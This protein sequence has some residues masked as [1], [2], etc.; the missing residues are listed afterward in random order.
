MGR[1]IVYYL[2]ASGECPTKIFMESLPAKDAK[3]VAWV[4]DLLE[5]LDRVPD[6]YFSKMA[7]TDEIWEC[8][9]TFGSN[10]YRV[11]A[12]IDGHKSNA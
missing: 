6:M 8:R 11:L 2:T 1:E 4:I 9:A 3:K 7:G 12:F 10:A 5:D